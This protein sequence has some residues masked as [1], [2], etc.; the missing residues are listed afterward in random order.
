MNN[1]PLM[2][3]AAQAGFGIAKLPNYLIEPD[4]KAG[5]LVRVLSDYELPCRAVCLV[6][7]DQRPLPQK[8]RVMILDSAVDRFHSLAT[9]HER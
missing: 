2:R 3:R 1:Y 9:P 4:V 7:T 8:V 6:F 5:A